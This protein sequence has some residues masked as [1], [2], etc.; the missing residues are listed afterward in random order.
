VKDITVPS[1]IPTV[2]NINSH[3]S[4]LPTYVTNKQV[5]PN[6]PPPPCK[7][8]GGGSLLIKQIKNKKD[9]KFNLFEA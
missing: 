8:S 3:K 5:M 1:W 7:G 4:I 9:D 6:I 2:F